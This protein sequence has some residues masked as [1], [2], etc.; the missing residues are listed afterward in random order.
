M[1]KGRKGGGETRE[2]QPIICSLNTPAGGVLNLNRDREKQCLNPQLPVNYLK[3]SCQKDEFVTV[4]VSTA[5][6][7]VIMAEDPTPGRAWYQMP[8]PGGS[9]RGLGAVDKEPPPEAQ[10]CSVVPGR[11]AETWV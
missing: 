6:A 11:L 4:S 7:A 8:L 9:Y 10:A 5:A 3:G 2:G 1:G